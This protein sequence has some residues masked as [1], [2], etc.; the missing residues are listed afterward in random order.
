MGFAQTAEFFENR[1]K[2]ANDA[3]HAR[4]LSEVAAFY[5][6][7]A[8]ITPDFPTGFNGAR[9]WETRAIECRAIAD[10]FTDSQSR[11]RMMQIA[12]TYDRMAV[13]AE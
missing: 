10:H 4:R 6:H 1:A 11:E 9:R 5:R 2:K 13:A 3:D 7:L 8:R 12:D